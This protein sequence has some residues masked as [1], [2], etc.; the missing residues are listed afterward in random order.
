MRRTIEKHILLN[1]KEAERLKAKAKKAGLSEGALIR[2]LL[3][4][5]TPKECPNESFHDFTRQLSAI[6]NSLNQLAAKANTL[7]FIDTPQI[8]KALFA[9][10]ELVLA[11]QREFLL[12]EKSEIKWQ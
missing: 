6:G 3:D 7:G 12:P 9:H 11:I 10:N 8:S 5:Y 2:S 1:R 4:G